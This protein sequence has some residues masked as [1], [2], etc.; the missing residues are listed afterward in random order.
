VQSLQ[1]L[2][3]AELERIWLYSAALNMI[4]SAFL[5]ASNGEKPRSN[6]AE[7]GITRAIGLHAIAIYAFATILA[8][9]TEF[10]PRRLCQESE[11]LPVILTTFFNL[12]P[13]AVATVK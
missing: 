4:I 6:S 12:P 1:I 2:K 10:E 8:I 9:A 5:L 13:A 11:R 7:N 3:R